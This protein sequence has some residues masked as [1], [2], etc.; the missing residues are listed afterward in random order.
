MHEPEKKDKQSHE[1]TPWTYLFLDIFLRDAAS[2]TGRFIMHKDNSD[3]T[4]TTGSGK[5][6]IILFH[7]EGTIEFPKGCI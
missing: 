7:W 1:R 2:S 4:F 6:T 3:P 5:W